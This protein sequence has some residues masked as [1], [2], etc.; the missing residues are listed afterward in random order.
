MPPFVWVAGAVVA[1]LL[2]GFIAIY[3]GLVA[4][5][6]QVQTAFST[7]DVML[8]KRFDLIPGLVA[9]VK[10]Y[11]S[12]ENATLTKLTELRARATATNPTPDQKIALG[13]ELGR[14]LT[15]VLAVAE[16]YPD[17]KASDGFRDLQRSLNETEEQLA[18]A[19]RAY[20]A[21]VVDLNN[22]V[23]MFPSNLV[24]R[25]FSYRKRALFEID[26]FERK[27]PDVATLFA[28]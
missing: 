26:D 9:T 27:N 3:N 20:N 13:A 28:R 21:A 10:Q 23:D 1:V 7:I 2:I 6:N 15:N 8:K 17:L 14:A 19:R 12:H 18:A 22:A 25:W 4:K 5:T 16:G 24:A 11:A